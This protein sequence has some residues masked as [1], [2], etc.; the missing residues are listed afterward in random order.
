MLRQ[1]AELLRSVS[2]VPPIITTSTTPTSTPVRTSILPVGQL[3][4]Q[5]E[6]RDA[7]ERGGRQPDRDAFEHRA[8]AVLELQALQEQHDLEALA[9]DARE[10]ERDEAERRGGAGRARAACGAGGGGGRS[11]RDQ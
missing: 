2:A 3:A 9:V 11:T 8:R 6:H 7:D 10:A 5:P 4:V 1:P